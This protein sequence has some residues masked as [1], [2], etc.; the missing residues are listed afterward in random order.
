MIKMISGGREG[1]TFL[2]NLKPWCIFL[3]FDVSN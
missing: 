3:Q 1:K 2:H